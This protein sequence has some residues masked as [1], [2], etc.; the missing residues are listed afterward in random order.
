MLHSI[1]WNKRGHN[2]P[3]IKLIQMLADFLNW[4]NWWAFSMREIFMLQRN[5]PSPND[6]TI[7]WLNCAQKYPKSRSNLPTKL[8]NINYKAGRLIWTKT[9]TFCINC[10]CKSDIKTVTISR[11][12]E[13]PCQTMSSNWLWTMS[14]Q[15]MSYKPWSRLT[16]ESKASYFSQHI[17]IRENQL[18]LT[19]NVSCTFWAFAAHPNVALHS[20]LFLL[21]PQFQTNNGRFNTSSWFYCVFRPSSH[22]VYFSFC[23]SDISPDLCREADWTEDV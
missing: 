2:R 22:F 7:F 4:P 9:F 8:I 15:T 1:D 14:Y 5:V 6:A 11:I 20:L 17:C 19:T 23:N 18:L 13:L 21:V 3:V 12:I 10:C 16:R